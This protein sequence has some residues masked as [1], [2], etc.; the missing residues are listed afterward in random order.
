MMIWVCCFRIQG[1]FIHRETAG[2]RAADDKARYER[3]KAEYD[4]D[5]GAAAA[6]EEGE[7]EL[8]AAAPAEEDDDDLCELDRERLANMRKNH[9][10]LVRAAQ[11]VHITS[12]AAERLPTEAGL[13][14]QPHLT[15]STQPSVGA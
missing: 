2:R 12:E 10:A 6:E 9:D 3:E 5:G 14:V 8:E 15:R 4:A 1:L 11:R 7:E 13:T